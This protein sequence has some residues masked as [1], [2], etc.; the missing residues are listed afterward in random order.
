MSAIRGKNPEPDPPRYLPQVALAT[1]AVVGLPLAVVTAIQ[2]EGG[3]RSPWLSML[4]AVGLSVAISSAGSAIWKRRPGSRDIVFGD[5]MLWGFIRRR[6]ADRRIASA[7]YLLNDP[8]AGLDAEERM[9]GLHMLGSS[10]ESRD[11]YTHGHTRRVTR[12]TEAIARRRGLSQEQVA[13]VRTAAALHDVGKVL[14]TRAILTKPGELTAEE[15]ESVKSHA[16][17]GAQMVATLDDDDLTATVRHHHER[18]DGSGYPDGLR[19]TAI[20]LGARIVAVADTF[21]AMTSSRPYRRARSHKA[22]LDTLSREG[23][24]TLD[25]DVVAAF[26]AY[27]SGRRTVAWGTAGIA[28]P[29]R[30][31]AW[32]LDVGAAPVAK[33]ITAAGAA[34]LIG[35]S[36]AIPELPPAGAASDRAASASPGDTRGSAA[37][38]GDRSPGGDI[39]AP[40]RR[41]TGG[42]PPAQAQAPGSRQPTGDAGPPVSQPSGGGNAQQGGGTAPGG[43]AADNTSPGGPGGGGGSGSGGG[44]TLPT[45]VSVPGT[46]TPAGGVELTAPGVDADVQ[47]PPVQLPGVKVELPAVELP[48]GKVELPL[49]GPR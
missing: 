48:G 10:L 44:T 34:A 15:F 37:A 6:R 25:A 12:Y 24:S 31:L 28:A 26:L 8:G 19:G 41:V 21:D 36:L 11:S 22:A 39:P 13:R 46:Q 29:Q 42:G 16:A 43:P 49:S 17:D 32:V 4:A 20:P 27:Y 7:T 47:L 23:G 38:P 1:L 35:S 5:L 45:E 9:E 33:G 14:T 2:L 3:L 40:G 30:L 18:L